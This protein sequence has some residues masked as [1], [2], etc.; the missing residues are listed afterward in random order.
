MG[1]G[2][3][4]VEEAGGCEDEGAGADRQH[5]R[6]GPDLLERS[7]YGVVE[8]AGGVEDLLE[9]VRGRD[10]DGVGGGEHRGVVLDGDRVAV[11]GL[12]GEP[13]TVQ[14]S[15]SYSGS[16]LV[17]AP[18]KIRAGMASSKGTMP[19]SARTATRWD[20]QTWPDSFT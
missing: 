20:G 11:R 5:P 4:S 6:A 2:G 3:A 19:G 14:V 12:H 13:S 7:S 18:P 16:S 10:H 1:R 17:K 8:L 15:T 9:L